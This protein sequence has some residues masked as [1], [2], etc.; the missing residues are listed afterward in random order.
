MLVGFLFGLSLGNHLATILVLPAII[1]FVAQRKGINLNGTLRPILKIVMVTLLGLCLYLYFPIRSGFPPSFNYAGSY[2]SKGVFTPIDFQSLEQLIR[3]VTGGE[4]QD[5]MF[6]LNAPQIWNETLNFAKYMWSA[7][8]GIGF[9]P[10]ILGLIVMI[11]SMRRV[12]TMTSIYFISHALF[13]INYRV[14]DKE[15][16]YLP[17]LLIWSVWIAV[18]FD[19]MIVTLRD[20]RNR[21]GSLATEA[22]LRMLIIGV[23]LLSLVWNWPLVDLSNDWSARERGEEIL[24]Q[25]EANALIFGYW[26]TIP[27]IE[28]LQEVENNRPDV[29]AINRFLITLEDMTTL[30]E[31]E[32]SLRP[33]YIDS[34]PTT[35]P[36]TIKWQSDGLLY[37][38][39]LR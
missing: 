2:T 10:G 13:F 4:F 1:P 25:V 33:I 20:E 23:V 36:Q 27:V 8:F 3:Y 18:G 39:E 31:Q 21:F 32:I 14:I 6:V 35:L 29:Q 12:G 26:D 38:L 22:L 19:W 34:V 15:T 16:M 11:K 30:I 7:F 9:G 37:K 17:N 28:F 24:R 5:L